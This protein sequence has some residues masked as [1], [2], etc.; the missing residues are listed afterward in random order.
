MMDK[1]KNITVASLLSMDEFKDYVLLAGK[2]GEDRVVKTVNVIDAPDIHEWLRGGE[3]LLTTGYIFKDNCGLLMQVLEKCSECGAAALFI[4]EKRFLETIP[5]TMLKRADE[6]NFPIVGMPYEYGFIDVI[7]P[8][9]AKLVVNQTRIIENYKE[10]HRTFTDIVVK[11]LGVDVLV[12]TLAKKMGK[13]I[14]I[15]DR[16][17]EQMYCSNPEN[18]GMSREEIEKEYSCYYINV[19]K[20]NCGFIAIMEKDYLPKDF[21]LVL[22]ENGLIAV[23][24]IMS[25]EISNREMEQKYQYHFVMDLLYGNIKNLLDLEHQSRMF[26]ISCNL[27]YRV[28]VLEFANAKRKKQLEEYTKLDTAAVFMTKLLKRHYTQVLV[29]RLSE[30]YVFILEE[31]NISEQADIFLKDRLTEAIKMIE[32]ETGADYKIG[33][34]ETKPLIFHARDSYEEAKSALVLLGKVNEGAK[35]QAYSEMGIYKVLMNVIS[36]KNV[37]NYCKEKIG[38]L[39]RHEKGEEL[40]NSLAAIIEND[41]NLKETAQNEFV[42]YNTIKYRFH[43]IEEILGRSLESTSAKLEVEMAVKIYQCRNL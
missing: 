7:N 43:K 10:V 42:H 33:I 18:E 30:R 12:D 24:V 28:M 41:W 16:I 23:Q 34:G 27:N 35:I 1:E 20:R 6:L 29:A 40:M 32:S 13:G 3:I 21:E 38:A 39:L 22:L 25:R 11:G 19:Y 15:F 2:G 26:G 37:G 31:E 36:D 4:K 14:I 8:V 17:N 9:M 5:E